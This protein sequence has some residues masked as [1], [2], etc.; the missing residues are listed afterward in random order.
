V[1]QSFPKKAAVVDMVQWTG[2]PESAAELKEWTRNGSTTLDTDGDGEGF[3]E[4]RE[5]SFSPPDARLWVA[6]QRSWE[7]L[8]LGH[9]VAKELDGNGFYPI[10]PEVL[11]GGYDLT[12]AGK[13]GHEVLRALV[14]DFG[15]EHR[16]C[17]V[18]PILDEID[19][20]PTVAP[21]AH[22]LIAS[23][24]H[25]LDLHAGVQSIQALVAAAL[26]YTEDPLL[27]R[28]TALREA[29]TAHR[30]F[31]E[32]QRSHPE[33]PTGQ[34]PASAE[35]SQDQ[36]DYVNRLMEASSIPESWDGEESADY[37]L[38]RYLLELERRVLALGGSLEAWPEE[39]DDGNA[40]RCPTCTS[41]E[42]RL[43][44]AAGDGGEVTRVC[45][46]AFHGGR[47]MPSVYGIRG[48]RVLTEAEAEATRLAVLATP[49]LTSEQVE[50]LGL[51]DK[52][53]PLDYTP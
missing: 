42:P 49:L 17:P 3:Y 11:K 6:H 30:Q 50:R 2:T 24:T 32:A 37:I 26:A 44:P 1:I 52:P 10:S 39:D 5:L 12:K 16:C 47:V 22:M 34:A 46:D 48:H 33:A 23:D 43:H 4:G 13:R 7:P 45:P 14:A 40:L 28:Y 27:P 9:W 25:A 21:A 36:A 31:L 15:D 20:L 38:E 51:I 18:Q 29:A 19:R 53:A 35:P 41:R 8:P